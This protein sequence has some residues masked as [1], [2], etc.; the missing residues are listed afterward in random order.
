V[1]ILQGLED[2]DKCRTV[3]DVRR[4]HGLLS[5]FRKFIKEFSKKMKPITELMKGEGAVEWTDR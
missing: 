4:I 3:S 5:Y 1:D 2:L